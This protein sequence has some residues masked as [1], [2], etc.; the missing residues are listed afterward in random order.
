MM[1][2][3]PVDQGTDR[4]VGLVLQVMDA[5]LDLSVRINQTVDYR[6]RELSI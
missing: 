5:H 3:S 4:I 6:L 2:F 1:R